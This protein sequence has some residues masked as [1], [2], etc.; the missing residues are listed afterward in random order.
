VPATGGAPQ[1]AADL[2]AHLTAD[3]EAYHVKRRR[4]AA[5]AADK[6]ALARG[7]KDALTAHITWA[8]KVR[9]VR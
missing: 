8:C 9:G 1:L 4:I 2:P 6:A 7:L 5:L 3:L